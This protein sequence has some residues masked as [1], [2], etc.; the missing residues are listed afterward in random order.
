MRKAIFVFVL[1]LLSLGVFLSVHLIVF[2]D[3]M[4]HIVFCDVGQGD[5]I[6][7]RTPS[8]IV[9]VVDGG[10]DESIMNCLA[11][12]LPFWERTITLLLL[13][14]PHADHYVGIIG[15]LDRYKV[16]SF[17]TEKLNNDTILFRALFERT[18]AHKLSTRH[19]YG[20]DAF[21]FKD[22]VTIRVL[23]PS[24]EY[25]AQTSPGGQIGEKAEFASLVLLVSY[26]KFSVLLTG[27]SQA[28]GI[29]DALRNSNVGK[30]SVLQVPHHGSR[31]GLTKDILDRLKPGLAVI[32]VGKNNYG[33]PSPEMIDLLRAKGI[34]QRETIKNGDIEIVTEGNGFILK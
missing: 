5:A 9:S 4:L 25:L 32:S 20:G 18:K 1:I 11:N 31:T 10:P 28:S 26:G 24:R 13:S 14:H 2:S 16:K 21:R 34:E 8:G 7:I 29:D 23:G 19:L 3:K 15:I 27:D 33:H 30:I 17:A 6:L 12:H 22:G